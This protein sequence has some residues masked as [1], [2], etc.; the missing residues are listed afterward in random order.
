MGYEILPHTADLRIRVQGRTLEEV[1]RSALRGMRYVMHPRAAR[2]SLDLERPITVAAPDIAT[3]LVDFLSDALTLAHINRQ[4]YPDAR[5]E[6]LSPTTVRAT[7]R[8]SRVPRF[9][10][11]IKA[12]TYHGMEVTR[13]QDGHEATVVFDV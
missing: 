13:M 8:G 11:D 7:L 3:L 12:A 2:R 5:I 10:R 1:L 9:A 4:V 6:E